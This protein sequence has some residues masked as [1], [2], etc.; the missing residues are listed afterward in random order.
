VGCRVLRNG[1]EDVGFISI[2]Y[3]D[4]MVGHIHVSWADPSKVR[5][6]VVVGSDMRIFFD[7]VNTIEQVRV[8]EKGVTMDESE[9]SSYGEHQL[10]VRDGDIISPR[11]EVS[12]PLKNQVNHFLECITNGTT[13]FT[14]GADGLTVVQVMTAIDRS[15]ALKGIPVAIEGGELNVYHYADLVSPVR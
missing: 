7:D 9:A 4:D 14:S 13:P 5:E 1:R 15:M 10:L 2:G 11:L 8:F 3:E 12:E 6:V